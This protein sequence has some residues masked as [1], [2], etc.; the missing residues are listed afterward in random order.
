[1]VLAVPA[2]TPK[3]IVIVDDETSFSELLAHMLG[4]HFNRPVLTFANPRT[5]SESLPRL[6]IG[7]LVTDYYMPHISGLDLIRLAGAL[8][9]KTPPC[10]LMT[11]HNFEETDN[12][13]DRVAHFKA[14]LAKPFRWQELARLIERHWP[15]DTG[16]AVLG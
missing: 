9:D 1:M 15:A 7:V 4:E 10:I 16:P 2:N 11:G 12:E 5:A 14:T 3:A 13:G 6:N 8:G